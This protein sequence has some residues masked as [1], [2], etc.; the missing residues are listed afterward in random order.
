MKQYLHFFRFFF[1]VIASIAAL[2]GVLFIVKMQMSTERKNTECLKT[3]R[4]FDYAEVLTE[5]EEENLEALIAKR[6]R[7]IECDIV[8]VTLYES[9]EEYAKSYIDEL[10]YVYPDE[11]VMVY[12]DNFYDDNKFGYDKPYGDGAIFVD[13]WYRESDGWSYSWFG[14]SGSVKDQYDSGEK[15]R[16]LQEEVIEDVSSYPYESYKLYVNSVYREMKGGILSEDISVIAILVVALLVTTTF[17]LVP[18][19]NNRGTKTTVATTY[20]NGGKPV[21]HENK[22]VFLGKSVATRIIQ[23]NTG[24][25]SGGGGGGIH[26]SAG[27]HSHGGGG[28]R[29]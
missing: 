19:M 8:I 3:Q 11:Y 6:E 29:R 9:M 17:I 22:D 24:N 18:I 10:G 21:F 7:Q 1:L 2:F 23:T 4:V 26:T 15:I 16:S 20:V 12:A 5:E 13:N 27:G 28:A 14:T 25:G